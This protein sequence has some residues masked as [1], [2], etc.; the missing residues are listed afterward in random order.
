MCT[1][2]HTHDIDLNCVTL[3]PTLPRLGKDNAE[4]QCQFPITRPRAKE[5]V[6][7]N[8]DGRQHKLF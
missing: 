6:I 3:I 5:V 7:G 8:I 2:A 1:S 4:A